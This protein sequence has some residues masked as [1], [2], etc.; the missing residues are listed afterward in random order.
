MVTVIPMM[1]VHDGLTSFQRGPVL[2]C[3]QW[4]MKDDV[5]LTVSP[6]GSP[7][8]MSSSCRRA[9]GQELATSTEEPI[10]SERF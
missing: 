10:C 8:Q 6:A 5:M 7:Y 3:R 4:A 1:G 2:H 9:L